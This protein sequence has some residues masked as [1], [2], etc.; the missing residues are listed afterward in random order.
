MIQ[1]KSP[2]FPQMARAIGGIVVLAIAY[3]AMAEI[4]RHLASTPQNVTPVWPP[5]GIA[6][7]AVLLFGNW[8]AYGVFL[9]S[10]LANFWAFQD[11][12]SFSSLAISTIPVLGIAIG[13]TLGTLLGTSLLRKS[14]HRC[15]PLEQ[16]SN[17]FK[18]LIL[19][20]M[21]GPSIN[22]TVGVTC[23]ALSGKVPWASY[24]IVWLT[25]WIS[26]VSGIFIVTPILL[27]W[28]TLIQNNQNPIWQWIFPSSVLTRSAHSPHPR[29]YPFKFWLSIEPFILVG[30]IILI[31]KVAFGEGY[32]LEYMLIPVLLWSAFRLGQSGATLLTFIVAEIAAIATVN[33]RGTFASEDIN[34]SLMQLQSFIGVITFTIL[35][36]TATISERAQAETKLRLAFAELA[37]TNETLEVRVQQRTQE[38][39]EKNITLN[40][41]LDTLKKAQVQMIQSEKMSA[42][43]QMV[44][45]IAHEINNPVNFIDGNINYIEKYTK[46]LLEVVKGYQTHCPNPPEPLQTTLEEIDLDFLNKDLPKLFQSLKVGT[47]RIQQVVLSLRNFSRLDEADRKTVDIH[48]GINNTLL[49]LQHRLKPKPRFPGIEVVTNYSQLPLVECY[50]GQLNQ[51][52]LSLLSNAIDALEDSTQPAS[53]DEQPSQ[54]KTIQ[55]S[56]HVTVENQVQITIADNGL[57]MSETVRSRIFDPFFTTKPVGKGTGLGLSISYQIVTEQHNG[58]IWCN[59]TLGE[60]TQFVVEIPVRQS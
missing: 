47:E 3:Y 18:F 38:L 17:V 34:Q 12:T 35:L 11:A 48:E 30:L 6:V 36:L 16:V 53:R 20:G 54:S 49:I 58:R 51:V 55:I 44:A 42:L 41:T 7:G 60:G 50:P 2:S 59:S 15:Y 33:G 43:G 31:G 4:S 24:G 45:G 10:F 26:N 29:S 22:A 52:V 27:S 23:L 9:G 14:T 32:H 8:I 19:A 21:V 56:T 39:N 46:N 57:G 1:Q 37:K 40:Q 25:W 28:G 5:D 13:T